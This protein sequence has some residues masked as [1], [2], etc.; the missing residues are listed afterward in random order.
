MFYG[1]Q[2]QYGIVKPKPGRTDLTSQINRSVYRYT[3]KIRYDLLGHFAEMD[4]RVI[5]I[6]TVG[7]GRNV[8]LYLWFLARTI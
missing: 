7:L 2:W 3:E 8:V 4:R 5:S 6:D 1:F